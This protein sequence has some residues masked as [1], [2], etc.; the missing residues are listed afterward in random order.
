MKNFI[1]KFATIAVSTSLVYGAVA[2]APIVQYE[3]E[4]ATA[5]LTRQEAINK[6]YQY[7]D[8]YNKQEAPIV[9]AFKNQYDGS[10]GHQI[11]AR[12]I[13]YMENGYSVYKTA[14]RYGENGTLDCSNFTKL[15]YGDFGFNITGASRQYNQVG[16]KVAGVSSTKVGT[17]SSG[18]A[19]YGIKGIE[20]LRPGDIL[21]YWA[22]TANNKYISHVSIYMGVINGKPAVINTASDRP[23]SIGIINNFSY[24]YGE[25]FLEARRLLP[26]DAWTPSAA[27]K[28]KDSGPVIP[29]SY[30]LP[31]QKAIVMPD[32]KVVENPNNGSKASILKVTGNVVNVR[33]GPGTSYS[34]VGSVKNGDTITATGSSSN[35]WIPVKLIN[36]KSGYIADWLVTY[37]ED[38]SN[39][40]NDDTGNEN[41]TPGSNLPDDNAQ[42]LVSKITGSIVNVRSAAST[43]SSILG[44]VRNG[45]EVTV[46]N[47]LNGWY[48]IDWV[49]KSGYIAN[50]LAS[51]PIAQNDQSSTATAIVTGGVVNLRSGPGKQHSVVG[52]VRNGESVDVIEAGSEWTKISTDSN[53]SGYVATWLLSL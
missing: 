40:G 3:A 51:N 18:Q 38:D 47:Q 31:P 20:N 34:I 17:S 46:K 37:T 16:T 28:Y 6:Y 13:W 9:K 7:Q 33:S 41:E 32:N 14:G 50:Y 25:K 15:V 24:W 48:E 29:K 21:T 23:T 39:N 26:N 44:V 42:Q 35:R 8:S 12:A 1:K 45:E 43:N 19:L 22:G 53:K 52:S 30:I 10:L 49:G 5:A 11:V 2:F 27:S 36:G 4:A